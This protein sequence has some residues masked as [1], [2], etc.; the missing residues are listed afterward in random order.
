MR[1]AS[2][3]SP[4]GVPDRLMLSGPPGGH[5]SYHSHALS[6]PFSYK[7]AA[8]DDE[9]LMNQGREKPI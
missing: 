5:I 4:D 6:C 9:P 1:T 2:G 3:L 8:H 7:I